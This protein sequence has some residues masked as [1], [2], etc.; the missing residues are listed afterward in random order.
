MKCLACVSGGTRSWPL[1][2]EDFAT[3]GI[4]RQ[5]YTWIADCFCDVCMEKFEAETKGNLALNYWLSIQP[6]ET[7]EETKPN[8]YTWHSKVSCKEVSQEF[9]SNLGQA[10]Q[11]I[12]R[13]NT[14]K[15]TKGQ[16]KEEIIKDLEK[17]QDFLGFEIQRLKEGK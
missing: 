12:W 16:T 5:G 2:P 10:I 15:T 3:R 6:I 11:Y 14:L 13:S 1:Y 8:Y 4:E 9:M 7:K 17:A